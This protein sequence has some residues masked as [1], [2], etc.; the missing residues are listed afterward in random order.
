MFSCT[1]A[2]LSLPPFLPHS[3]RYTILP[4][5]FTP[6]DETL[7]VDA[8]VDRVRVLELYDDVVES[9]YGAAT[10][11]FFNMCHL[12]YIRQN[13]AQYVYTF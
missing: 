4:E 5:Q 3:H 2:S 11:G 6:I 13:L 7:L 10:T 1:R 8:S 9:M 12:I